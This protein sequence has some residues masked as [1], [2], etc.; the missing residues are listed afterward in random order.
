MPGCATKSQESLIGRVN[1]VSA[2]EA[3][4]IL[5]V[6][7]SGVSRFSDA[8]EPESEDAFLRARDAVFQAS[9]NRCHYCGFTSKELMH[10]H[11]LDGNHKNNKQANI[12][13]AD[14]LC[15]YC[16]H[17]GFVGVKGMGELVLCEAI[18]Q[19]ELN[20]L[21]IIAWTTKFQFSIGD[22]QDCHLAR[23]AKRAN[24]AIDMLKS[25][26]S[27]VKLKYGFS[28]PLALAS[29]MQEM[30][31]ERYAKRASLFP[32]VRLLFN[33]GAFTREIESWSRNQSC[34]A[35]MFNANNWPKIAENFEGKARR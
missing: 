1:E 5:G 20:C 22:G 14:P 13:C 26:S 30:N 11:H 15:H 29:A 23:I 12:V 8:P 4:L 31:N 17:L 6:S 27:Q 21:Q 3:E 28:D 19:A 25:S 18:T 16:N 2:P 24:D 34:L 7:R 10:G 35:G 33:S 9:G 32:G